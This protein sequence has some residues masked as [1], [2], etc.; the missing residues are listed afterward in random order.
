MVDSIGRSAVG[1]SIMVGR[2]RRNFLLRT[3]QKMEQWRD[4]ARV[5]LFKQ[6]E[7]YK[8]KVEKNRALMRAKKEGSL[9]NLNP[10]SFPSKWD[11]GFKPKS[12]HRFEATHSTVPSKPKYS[13]V[14][15]AERIYGNKWKAREAFAQKSQKRLKA[16]MKRA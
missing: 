13:I 14:K 5:N 11:V 7:R 9:P 3:I 15:P 4:A 2:R 8:A 1:R 12:V 10:S 6:R 16:G